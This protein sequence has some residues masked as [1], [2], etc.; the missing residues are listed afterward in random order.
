MEI[1]PKYEENLR[2]SQ[3]FDRNICKENL[4]IIAGKYVG[5][6]SVREIY[7]YTRELD[8][9]FCNFNMLED[10]VS[11]NFKRCVHGACNVGNKR[12]HGPGYL[13]IVLYFSVS[14]RRRPTFR[15]PRQKYYEEIRHDPGSRG[16]STST[17]RGC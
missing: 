12:Q 11:P 5:N 15:S 7:S 10:P 4:R 2:N 1:G 9:N 17:G 13:C 8:E 16:R 14:V 6:V 3:T